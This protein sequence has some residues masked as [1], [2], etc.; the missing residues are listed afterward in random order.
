M[1]HSDDE[2]DGA[3]HAAPAGSEAGFKADAVPQEATNWYALYALH[4]HEK[5][6]S[7]HLGQIGFKVFLPLYREVH[8]WSDRRKHVELPMFPCYVFFSGDLARRFEILNTPGVV[9]LVCSG[10]QV[11]VI[12]SAELE[13]VRKVVSSA[14]VVQPHPF[15]QCGER[16][17]VRSGPLKGVEGVVIRKKDSMRLVL[18]VEM[19]R[20][21]VAVE[22]DGALVERVLCD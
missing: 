5:A 15:V 22:V 18:S 4:Q 21:S 3:K 8:R 7:R 17:R 20:C 9:S 13:A 10:G 14:S 12:P 19:L 1:P 2:M 16:I 6:V 11:G